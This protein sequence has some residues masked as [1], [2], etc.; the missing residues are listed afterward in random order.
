MEVDLEKTPSA[1]EVFVFTVS[2]GFVVKGS[3]D[4]VT[5]TVSAEDWPTFELAGSGDTIVIRSSQVVALRGSESK[6]RRSN[7]GFV[8]RP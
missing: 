3:I 6:Q 4:D 7:I 5:A 1:G 8:H 2:G